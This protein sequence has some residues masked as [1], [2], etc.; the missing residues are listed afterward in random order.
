MPPVAVVPPLPVAPPLAVAPPLPVVPPVAVVP[1][2]PVVPPVA[3]LPPLPV[4]PPPLPPPPLAFEPPLELEPPLA[5][6]PPDPLPVDVSGVEHPT[7]AASADAPSQ[8]SR[9]EDLRI[10]V[11]EVTSAARRGSKI[12]SVTILALLAPSFSDREIIARRG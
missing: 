7:V 12:G 11:G 8:T 6:E 5:L 1:P 3:V 9:V 10:F 4:D 2:L